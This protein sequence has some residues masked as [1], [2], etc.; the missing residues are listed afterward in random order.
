MAAV[1]ASAPRGLGSRLLSGSRLPHG[2]GQVTPPES[3]FSS[4]N[5]DM[6]PR[7]PRRTVGTRNGTL[8]APG[9]VLTLT[10]LSSLQQAK[11]LIN[12]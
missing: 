6:H 11:E 7:L 8:P 2:L 4:T 3:V 10:L 1:G 5:R 9:T 12:K